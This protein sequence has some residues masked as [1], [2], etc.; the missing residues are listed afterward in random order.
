MKIGSLSSARDLCLVVTPSPDSMLVVEG[1]T[2]YY[3]ESD[4]VV[5]Y[6]VIE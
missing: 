4:S 1:F 3:S 5:M 6:E 2:E